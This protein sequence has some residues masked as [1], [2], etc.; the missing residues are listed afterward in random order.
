MYRW[1]I[2]L[3]T[4]FAVGLCVS[5]L[6]AQEPVHVS[7]Q[8]YTT[9]PISPVA[10]P[11]DALARPNGFI[12][13]D[14]LNQ[15]LDLKNRGLPDQHAI[16]H[17]YK[18]TDEPLAKRYWAVMRIA[19][20]DEAI[21]KLAGV[22]LQLLTDKAVDLQWRMH[23]GGD[24]FY[25]TKAH[26]RRTLKLKPGKN[27]F[28]LFWEDLNV[29]KHPPITGVELTRINQLGDLGLVR[30]GLIFK[31]K[32][33]ADDYR[34]H[35]DKQLADARQTMLRWIADRGVKLTSLEGKLNDDRLEKQ[36]WDA[37]ALLAFDEVIKHWGQLSED[38]S[39]AQT[40][41]SQRQQ[42]IRQLIAGAD[43]TTSLDAYEQQ[44][45]QWV[46]GLAKQIPVARRRW[47]VA[48]DGRF[49][50][51]TGQP[52]RMYGPH[53]FRALYNEKDPSRQWKKWDVKYLAGM[54]FNGLRLHVRWKNIEPTQG[55]FN[56]QYL[57]IMLD[58]MQEAERYGLAVSVDMHWPFPDWFVAGQPD[59]PTQSKLIS[60]V[61]HNIYHWPDAIV[62]AWR[63]MAIAFKDSPNILAFEVP[64]NE[65]NF[66][67]GPKGMKDYPNMVI[68]W[69]QWLKSQYKTREALAKAWA[70]NQA[71]SEKYQLKP[72]E[73]WADNTIEP[74]G[75][76]EDEPV[77]VNHNYMNNPRLW[78]HL[79]FAAYLQ[80][81]LSTRIMSVIRESIPDAVG[82]S[83]RTIGD[84]YDVSRV[85]ISY[86]AI[87]TLFGEHVNIGTHY[88]MGGKT[89]LEAKSLTLASYDSE[90]QMEHASKLVERHVEMG[91]GFCPFAFH[92]RGSGGMLLAD[93]DWH[94][95]SST[96]YLPGMS[97]WIRSHWPKP[98]YRPAVAI[99]SNTR[100]SAINAEKT[101]DLIA[102]LDARG[103][104]VKLFEGLKIVEQP[105]LLDDCKAVITCSSYMDA[106]LLHVLAKTYKGRVL[107]FGRLDADALCRPT[108]DGLP[109]MLASDHR[110]IKQPNLKPLSG[111]DLGQIDLTGSWAWKHLG[112]TPKGPEKLPTPPIS[113]TTDWKKVIV[114][115]KWGE[116]GLLGSSRYFM[117]DAW[118]VRTFDVPANWKGRT[119]TFQAGAMDDYDWTFINGHFIGK[120]TKAQHH[121]WLA[122]REYVIP[123]HAIKWG[124][125][126]T[127]A[128]RLRN[129]FEDA[130][131]WKGPVQ[132]TSNP[133]FPINWQFPVK[134]TGKVQLDNHAPILDPE[135]LLDHVQV[136]GTLTLPDGK[137]VP[138]FL[139]HDQWYWWIGSQA[140]QDQDPIQQV[141]LDRFLQYLKRM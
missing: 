123:D 18:E 5:A 22:Q 49:T 73:N 54:G 36:A 9:T 33:G 34:K 35:T 111:D 100:L 122:P 92:A 84:M 19:L 82:M 43:I 50:R 113:E 93:D 102:M 60:Q 124:Q 45:N 47:Y 8:D 13:S 38:E 96:A 133:N 86:Y 140:W 10:R 135:N 48:E 58:I 23:S 69:N 17:V 141:V 59:M 21:G 6:Q 74:L 11:L 127:I 97:Q 95:K 88:G 112:Q 75:Y 12:R 63:R 81:S 98:D 66:A 24:N 116:V 90:R 78:D 30:I 125:T 68:Q 39:K 61:K 79:R 138:A 70:G 37:V 28:D 4:L 15:H 65:S 56:Q 2:S 108:Q 51:P 20:P 121:Y 40:F 41:E 134:Q 118:H 72:H 26:G 31:D 120:T 131:I 1:L 80:K 104:Q 25:R 55:Q 130:G 139:R 87:N 91:L 105:Q 126:N 132:I 64:T 46:D 101:G 83:Q 107:L 32:Q 129:D 119:L 85:P 136:Q 94:M 115:G 128:I 7:W 27:T 16:W 137:E 117:G 103:Y 57:Q 106:D 109:A 77:D 99:V 29:K 53:F 42:L 67:S 14:G 44:L 89:A 52:F 71:Q 114:P 62:D 76:Q 110:F 3:C